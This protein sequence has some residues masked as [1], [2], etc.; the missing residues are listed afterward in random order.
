MNHSEGHYNK[1][2]KGGN[3]AHSRESEQMTAKRMMLKLIAVTVAPYILVF[4]LIYFINTSDEEQNMEIQHNEETFED[5][6]QAEK[7]LQKWQDSINAIATEAERTAGNSI[8]GSGRQARETARN[9]SED[10]ESSA[11]I[12]YLEYADNIGDIQSNAFANSLKLQ[13]VDIECRNI[14]NKA[15]IGCRALREVII[16]KSLTEIGDKAFAECPRLRTI[17]LPN[18]LQRIGKDIFENTNDIR[19]ISIPY[20]VREELCT[21]IGKN[22]ALGTLYILGNKFFKLP[23]GLKSAGIDRR[24]MTIYVPDALLVDFCKDLEWILFDQILPLSQSVWY[25]SKGMY[26]KD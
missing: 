24:Q 19:E 8:N 5:M 4:V 2:E 25:D 1:Q 26:K 18:S 3:K 22:S 20:R 17:L 9:V 21:Q 14:G 11:Q 16:R 10:A 13:S 7:H 23:Q 15:F 12:R 6:Q